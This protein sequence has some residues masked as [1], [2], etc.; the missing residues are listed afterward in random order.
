MARTLWHDVRMEDSV[1]T[2]SGTSIIV[3]PGIP[4]RP[5]VRGRTFARSRDI[6]ALQDDQ[7]VGV[8]FRL[9]YS[10]NS[11]RF[12]VAAFGIDRAEIPLEVSGAFLRTVRVHAIARIGILAA[13]PSW[14]LELAQLRNLRMRG[15]LRSFADF[16]PSDEEALLLTGLLYRI[17]EISGENPAQAVAE[18]VG[19]KQRTA[20]NWIQRARAAG[21]LTSTDHGKAARRV[22]KS[23]EPLWNA[24]IRESGAEFRARHNITEES[25][26]ALVERENAAVDDAMAKEKSRGDD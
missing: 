24:Y 11:G 9:E 4:L 2:P 6:G 25:M 23:I 8:T 26:R 16:A 12:E 10:E 14:A 20:T 7:E 3:P 22:A 17:A 18:S 15:G 19:L 1:F 5:V 13:I 21:Y